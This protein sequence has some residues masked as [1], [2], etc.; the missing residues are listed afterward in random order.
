MKFFIKVR[1]LEKIGYV[2]SVLHCSTSKVLIKIKY[3]KVCDGNIQTFVGEGRSPRFKMCWNDD[4]RDFKFG[5][6]F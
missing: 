1:N 2:H 4:E 6:T 3:K 5:E